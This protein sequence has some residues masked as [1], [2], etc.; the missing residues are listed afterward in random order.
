VLAASA[1]RRGWTG[2]SGRK[3][4]IQFLVDDTVHPAELNFN[5]EPMCYDGNS[6]F[7]FDGESRPTPNVRRLCA[8]AFVR[9]AL[10][11]NATTTIKWLVD[12]RSA[13]VMEGIPATIAALSAS[14]VL[15]PKDGPLAA[16]FFACLRVVGRA[17]PGTSP[18]PAAFEKCARQ[19]SGVQTPGNKPARCCCGLVQKGSAEAFVP[20]NRRG[21]AA[22]ET[23][24]TRKN[25]AVSK[26]SSLV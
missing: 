14:P 16:R 1:L 17:S 26:S 9:A 2:A 5:A 8:P 4:T 24:F 10:G 18:D 19:H 11:G 20:P 21:Q 6:V 22:D 15:S 3:R 23:M 7:A 25:C 13:R 12:E